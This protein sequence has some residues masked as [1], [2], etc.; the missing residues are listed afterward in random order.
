MTLQLPPASGLPL[1][2]LSLPCDR[3]ATNPTDAAAAAHMYPEL[4]VAALGLAW[5]A[6]AAGAVRGCDS[7]AEVEER[8]IGDAL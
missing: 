1:Q 3:I 6:D 8:V 4:E 5:M 7:T 2:L